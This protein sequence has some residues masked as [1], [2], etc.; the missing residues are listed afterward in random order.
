[1]APGM[2]PMPPNTAA[3][4]A[5]MPGMEPGGGHQGGVGGAQKHARDGRK[6]GADGEGDGDGGVHV[7]PHQARRAPYPRKRR[8][9]PCPILVR[10]VNRVSTAMITI[11]ARM[12]TMV[13]PEITSLP[14]K[15]CRDQLPTTEENT[16]GLEPQIRRGRVLQKIGN[17]DGRDQDGEGGSLTKR[18][19]GEPFDGDAQDRADDH[20]KEHR[21]QGRKPQVA[22]GAEGDV[23]AH[24]DDVAVREIQH[25]GNAVDHRVAQGDDGV[26]AAQADAADQMG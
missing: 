10:E 14:S 16:F 26:H 11:Q 6:A 21:T 15:S 3:V 4:K 5:L 22:G 23:G 24:H 19:I 1:M 9:W 2:E 12:D 17:A 8:A 25:F 18:L 20:R 13:T 7:D